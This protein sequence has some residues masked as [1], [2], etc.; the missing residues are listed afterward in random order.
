[1][2]DIDQEKDF[3]PAKA[4][5]DPI[6]LGG[7]KYVRAHRIEEPDNHCSDLETKLAECEARLSKAM[8]FAEGVVRYAGNGGDDYLADQARAT[9]AELTGGNND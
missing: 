6:W 4:G 9:L 8:S 3:H 5:D 7:M 2:S 1:M